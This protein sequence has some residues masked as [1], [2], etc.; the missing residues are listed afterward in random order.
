M[1]L[2]VVSLVVQRTRLA[3]IA[4]KVVQLL[5]LLLVPLLVL[6]LVVVVGVEA[7]SVLMLGLVMVSP[8]VRVSALS[9]LSLFVLLLLS[10]MMMMMMMTPSHL[11]PLPVQAS[12]WVMMSW[13]A[14]S[15]RNWGVLREHQTLL[16]LQK[17]LMQ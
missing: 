14:L 7:K 8:V 11:M 4:L 15:A 2:A 5:S 13:L 16:A 9:L 17:H 3:G 10:M 1:K 6:L 12:L